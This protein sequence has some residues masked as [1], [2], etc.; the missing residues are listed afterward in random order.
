MKTP[1]LGPKNNGS[2]RIP[3]TLGCKKIVYVNL[4]TYCLGCCFVYQKLKPYNQLC[5]LL[6]PHLTHA[7]FPVCANFYPVS[8]VPVYRSALAESTLP[9]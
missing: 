3:F 1:K 8:L 7:I 5:V 9:V 4:L 6:Y 2:F